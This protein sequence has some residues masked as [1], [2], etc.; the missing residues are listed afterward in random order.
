ME[1]EKIM[2]ELQTETKYELFSNKKMFA[3]GLDYRGT[4]IKVDR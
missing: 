2:N 3:Y 1:C 4:E